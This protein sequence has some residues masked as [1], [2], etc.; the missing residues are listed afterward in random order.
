ML[1][2]LKKG[3]FEK[4]KDAGEG[5][6]V[7]TD[8]PT[9]TTKLHQVG[10]RYVDIKSFTTKVVENHEENGS[11]YWFSDKKDAVSETNADECLVC[12]G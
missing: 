5:Y 3:D 1:R 10:C 12:N 8:K 6:I 9:N 4:L 2:V 11:Y 7:I